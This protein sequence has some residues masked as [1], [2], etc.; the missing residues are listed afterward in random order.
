[1]AEQDEAIK[2]V[3]EVVD[4][5]SKPLN[6]LKKELDRI[7]DRGGD[8]ATKVKKHFDG[9]REAATNVGNALNSTVV[10]ALRAV[11]I[12]FAGVGATITAAVVA[13]KGFAGTTEVLS[14]LSRETGVSIDRMREL[15]AVGR[16]LGISAGEM[17]QGFREFAAE[18]HKTRLGI[19]DSAKDLRA[20][21]LGEF[22]EQLR[23][24]KTNAEALEIILQKLD[25]IHD[26]QHRRDFLK[27]RGLP[28]GLADANRKE[29]E[30]LIKE[31]R[32]S[33]GSTTKA[34]EDAADRFEHSI[35]RMGNAFEALTQKMTTEGSLDTLTKSLTSI[36]DLVPQLIKGINQFNDL[37][38]KFQKFI[39][40]PE[41]PTK[42]WEEWWENFKQ[43]FGGGGSTAPAAPGATGAPTDPKK[44]SYGSGTFGGAQVIRASLIGGDEEKTKDTIA[45]GVVEGLKK[46]A[47]DEGRPEGPGAHGGTGGDGTGG[48]AP[49]IRASL[50]GSPTNR[51]GNTGGGDGDGQGGDGAK[52]GGG[53]S[54]PNQGD[55][56]YKIGG[57]VT[58]GGKEFTWGS[59]GAK[60]GSLPYGDFPVNIGDPQMGPWGRTHGAI[61]TIGGAGGVIDDPKYPGRPRAGIEIHPGSGATLDRLY[62]E[63]CFAVPRQQW[64]A[65]KK[66]LLE[67]SKKGPLMLHVGRGGRAQIM[68]RQ[69][70]ATR[71]GGNK[72]AGVPLPRARPQADAPRP[73]AVPRDRMMDASAR[74]SQVAKIEGAA[75]VRIDLAG[76]GNAPK[77]NS[78]PT[79]GVFSEVQLHRGNTIPYA[80]ESA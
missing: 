7:S 20:R 74:Q 28:P 5:F 75:S 12:G 30:K 45:E 64:P 53:G 55:R 61:A 23:H 16:R 79:A 38:G 29:R 73:P 42:S 63:G 33:V 52:A 44:L 59:G 66:A 40:P 4:K 13:L 36:A 27:A 70:W 37:Y 11:G 76:Y 39:T 46:W 71:Y 3:V 1:M 56:P 25:Q 48:G 32:D 72:N 34:D 35:W 21:G 15:E 51:G 24:T 54:D 10:P 69:D 2:V 65:F 57:K 77:H 14:R 78:S 67:E 50:G 41:L 9:L 49:V 8:G 18:M 58:V 68:T 62:S 26:P 47:L 22:A 80:N 19:G 43:R 6:D 17:R 31:W 60:R